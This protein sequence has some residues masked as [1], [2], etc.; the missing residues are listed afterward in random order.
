MKTR[1][2]KNYWSL[3]LC[4]FEAQPI[5]LR[6]S[7]KIKWYF[8]NSKNKSELQNTKR[9]TLNRLKPSISTHSKTRT[10]PRTRFLKC[11]VLITLCCKTKKLRSL[12]RGVVRGFEWV[13]ILGFLLRWYLWPFGIPDNH[14]FKLAFCSDLQW[15]QINI[16]I[17]KK[18]FKAEGQE[19]AKT[20]RSIEQFIRK[21]K[22]QN[23]FLEISQI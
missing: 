19:L 3:K 22:G 2:P 1:L 12:I 6:L 21:V 16:A 7:L 15:E 23:L 13:E 4:K 14:I 9:N 11:F 20:L 10:T 5:N 18:L 8:Y 17:E